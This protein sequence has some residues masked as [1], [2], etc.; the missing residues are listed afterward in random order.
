M[1]WPIGYSELVFSKQLI[2][3]VP[4]QTIPSVPLCTLTTTRKYLC[5]HPA[6]LSAFLS[7]TS[8]TYIYAT[9]V[10]ET[11]FLLWEWWERLPY[12]SVSKSLLGLQYHFQSA[13]KAG[14]SQILDRRLWSGSP[15][16]SSGHS[17]STWAHSL[18]CNGLLLQSWAPIIGK[19]LDELKMS[20]P[21]LNFLLI[22]RQCWFHP[23]IF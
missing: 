1:N 15:Q 21:A 14:Q 16:W 22:I 7:T 9:L 20:V 5:I 17:G 13:H 11:L 6:A 3:N 2:L 19:W 8:P 12:P 23:I 10:L 4:D 18:A